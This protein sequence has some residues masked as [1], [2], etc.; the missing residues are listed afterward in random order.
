MG[1]VDEA[2][3]SAMD[4][5]SARLPTPAPADTG[6]RLEV[7]QWA[8]GNIGTGALRA[9]LGHPGLALT[10]VYVHSPEKAGQDAGDLCGLAPTGIRA[11]HDIDEILALGADC[12]LYM[13][14]ACD[15][16]EVCRILASGAN[17][18]AADL[19]R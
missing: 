14:R 7:V 11:T 16:D 2:D 4:R 13:P 1:E 19:L 12:V 3:E 15:M 17:T 6:E 10:G 9:V 8:T 18:V 5:G